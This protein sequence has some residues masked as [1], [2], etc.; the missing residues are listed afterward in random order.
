MTEFVAVSTKR[1][2]QHRHRVHDVDDG[3]PACRAGSAD[4]PEF[5]IVP[6]STVP[7]LERCRHCSGDAQRTGGQGS[8]L[9]AKLAAADPTEVFGE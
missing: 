6:R 8:A 1:G 2:P 3:G 7:N 9:A 5:E 4:N